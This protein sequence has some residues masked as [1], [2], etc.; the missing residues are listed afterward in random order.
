MKIFAD[1]ANSIDESPEERI[2]RNFDIGDL[3][4]GPLRGFPQW[5]GKLVHETE[6]RGNPKSEDGKVCSNGP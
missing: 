6:V 5:P 2:P 4:W 1:D 3:I